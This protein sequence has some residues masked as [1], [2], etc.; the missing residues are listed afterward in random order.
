MPAPLGHRWHTR[1][2]QAWSQCPPLGACWPRLDR[3]LPSGSAGPQPLDG[4]GALALALPS[5]SAE[6]SPPSSTV[7]LPC[8][9]CT[10]WLC[11]VLAVSSRVSCH[12]DHTQVLSSLVCRQM[13][14][15]T[16][17]HFTTSMASPASGN[18]SLKMKPGQVRGL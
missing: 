17:G 13:P 10:L 18:S 14:S 12:G 4:S 6:S 2:D 5:G 7:P 9:V 11:C 15:T 16:T 1:A 8:L 3:R